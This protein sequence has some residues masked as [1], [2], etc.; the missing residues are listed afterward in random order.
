MSDNS[1]YFIPQHQNRKKNNKKSFIIKS[2]FQ[3][4]TSFVADFCSFFYDF[5]QTFEIKCDPVEYANLCI[6]AYK[7]K[8]IRSYCKDLP[9]GLGRLCVCEYLPNATT[10]VTEI[11]VG[12]YRKGNRKK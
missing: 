5:G 12:N 2:K 8:L 10:F 3:Y 4:E 11:A 6:N 9:N 1:P 7:M